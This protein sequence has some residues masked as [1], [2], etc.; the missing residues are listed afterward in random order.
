MLTPEELK[1]IRERAEKATAGEWNI[2]T[3]DYGSMDIYADS[4][5]CIAGGTETGAIYEE[6]N[7][8]FIAHSREDIPALLTHIQ[9][10]E[11]KLSRA[12]E[13]ICDEYCGDPAARHSTECQDVSL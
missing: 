13:L 3:T 1:A 10:L 11:A 12:R 2:R 8:A 6:N 4:L 7:A 9:E 5:E